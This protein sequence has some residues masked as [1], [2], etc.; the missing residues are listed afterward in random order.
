MHIA[1]DKTKVT[2][3][4]CEECKESFRQITGAI[5]G[6]GQPLGFFMISAHGHSSE[7]RLAHLAM[8]LCSPEGVAESAAIAITAVGKNFHFRFVDWNASPWDSEDLES[9]LDREAAEQ[10]QFRPTFLQAAEHTVT[11]VPQVAEYF[12]DESGSQPHRSVTT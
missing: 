9:K 7:G 3:T 11:D 2:E 6:D 10:S 5:L 8:A 12:S 4:R 1:L